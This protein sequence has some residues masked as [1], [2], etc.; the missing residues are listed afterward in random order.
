MTI[1]LIFYLYIYTHI[2]ISKLP[3]LKDQ[4]NEMLTPASKK[5]FGSLV[6]YLIFDFRILRLLLECAQANPNI[7]LWEEEKKLN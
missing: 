2:Y 1:D 6:V 5:Y 3:M 7:M 4:Y